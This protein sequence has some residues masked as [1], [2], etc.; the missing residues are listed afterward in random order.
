MKKKINEVT[1]Y[2]LDPQLQDVLERNYRRSYGE[3]FKARE[4]R[5]RRVKRKEQILTALIIIFILIT[6][7]MLLIANSKLTNK[8]IDKCIA[9]GHSENYCY[10]KLA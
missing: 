7:C 9:N 2:T 5:L 4:D 6:T 1:D 3:S 8:T 10:E